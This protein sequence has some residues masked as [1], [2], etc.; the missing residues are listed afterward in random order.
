[1]SEHVDL[2]R[3]L[4]TKMHKPNPAAHIDLTIAALKVQIDNVIEM[5]KD[6][7]DKVMEA[8]M[9]GSPPRLTAAA[10][11]IKKSQVKTKEPRKTYYGSAS[12]MKWMKEDLIFNPGSKFA[13][14]DI[15]VRLLVVI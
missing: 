14:I 7:G 1:M 9:K 8:S 3:K 2:W 12:E 5:Y 4:T 10:L 15:H 11:K 13:N 6:L